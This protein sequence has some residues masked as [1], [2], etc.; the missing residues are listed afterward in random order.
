MKNQRTQTILLVVLIVAAVIV[1]PWQLGLFGPKQGPATTASTDTKTDSSSTTTA[2][3][4]KKPT[5]SDAELA[6]TLGQLFPMSVLPYPP[7]DPFS[8]GDIV[9]ANLNAPDTAPAPSSPSPRPRPSGGTRRPSPMPETEPWLPSPL[10]GGF[11]PGTVTQGGGVA[12]PIGG[13]GLPPSLPD[14]QAGPTYQVRGT[15][16]G[17]KPMAVV[18]DNTGRQRIVRIG[19]ELESGAKV[20]GIQ[21]NRV[22]VRK[23]GKQTNMTIEDGRNERTSS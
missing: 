20:V 12:G 3:A 17:R 14:I 9:A 18:E 7:R 1:V 10:P 4:T 13:G 22:I 16:T 15:M 11:G 23:D 5:S 21:G 2:D 19:D 8:G 6:A